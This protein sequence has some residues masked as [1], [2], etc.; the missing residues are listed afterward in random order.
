M[1]DLEA[2]SL[3]SGREIE[4]KFILHNMEIADRWRGGTGFVPGFALGEVA[5]VQEVDTYFDSTDFGLLRSGFTLRL[6]TRESNGIVRQVVGYKDIDFH[7]PRGVHSRIEVEER[8]EESLP[9]HRALHLEALPPRIAGPLSETLQSQK[10]KGGKR[11]TLLT[12]IAQVQQTRHK[13]SVTRLRSGRAGGGRRSG[14]ALAPLGEL[15]VDDLHFLTPAALDNEKETR[16]VDAGVVC[17]VEVEIP[18]ADRR[19]DLRTLAGKMQ[20]MEGVESAE[21]GKVQIALLTAAGAR[22]EAITSGGGRAHTAEFCRAI[23]GTQLA[24][25]LVNEAGVRKSDDIEYVHQMRVATRRARAAMRLYAGFFAEKNR[26]IRGFA[27]ALR[28]TGWL[29]GRVRDLD[30]AA[31]RLRHFADEQSAGKR[32]SRKANGRPARRVAASIR[33]LEESRAR[34]HADLVEWLDSKKYARFVA[35]FARFCATP[36]RGV[37]SIQVEPGEAPLPVQLRHTLPSMVWSR[38]EAVRAFEPLFE[39]A[40]SGGAV[41]VETLH[42]LRIECKY[43]RYHLEFAAPLLGEEGV[44]LITAIKVLQEELGALNDAVVGGEIISVESEES[45]RDAEPMSSQEPADDTMALWQT[46][47]QETI[48]AMRGAIPHGFA[49]FV[50]AEN[51]QRLASAVA[52]L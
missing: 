43:L 19:S 10:G 31:E 1:S 20:E 47:Q 27:R 30:V 5:S 2:E 41:P 48:A 49:A 35:R 12:P 42:A 44:A 17:M 40:Q 9:V 39:G 52:R 36:G 50:G 37:P 38:F 7:T 51:R 28:T 16:W 26:A 25:M 23:W 46:Q 14:D 15:S 33:R 4:A 13:M 21:L 3:L 18:A 8:L 45:E 32:G 24:A 6:R 11:E 34:A 22:L 29:L